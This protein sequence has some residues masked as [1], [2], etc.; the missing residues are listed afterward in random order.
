MCGALRACRRSARGH[1]RAM[2]TAASVAAARQ[3]AR[4]R[5]R[6]VRP[7]RSPRPA[8]ILRACVPTKRQVAAPLAGPRR[9]AGGSPQG[10][11]Q[12]RRGPPQL[13]YFCSR[14]SRTA[15][16]GQAAAQHPD[17]PSAPPVPRL[18]HSL[19][20]CRVFVLVWGRGSAGSCHPAPQYWLP[21]APTEPRSGFLLPVCFAPPLSGVSPSVLIRPNLAS[22]CAGPPS[23]LSST[24]VWRLRDEAELALPQRAGYLLKQSVFSS[25]QLAGVSFPLS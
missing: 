13:C 5:L 17:L 24:T 16:Q 3:E 1:S 2:L 14:A 20:S 10:S 25:N 19:P 22:P 6:A 23:G 7:R 9:Q 11:P 4:R 18:F 21:R 12:A 8:R 15:D